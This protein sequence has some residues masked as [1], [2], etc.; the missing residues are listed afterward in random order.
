M[1]RNGNSI[2]GRGYQPSNRPPPKVFAV[3]SR[4]GSILLSTYLCAF[5]VVVIS[6]HTPF[7]SGRVGLTSFT[8]VYWNSCIHCTFAVYFVCPLWLVKWVVKAVK[9]VQD[10]SQVPFSSG[11]DHFFCFKLELAIAIDMH[12][13]LNYNINEASGNEAIFNWHV[14]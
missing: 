11:R 10:A 12:Q 9:V 5:I 1:G 13:W 6:T 2:V 3:R 8:D 14:K 4:H 7:R